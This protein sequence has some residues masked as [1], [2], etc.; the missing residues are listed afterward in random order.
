MPLSPN[1]M[2]PRGLFVLNR[3]V[4][5]DPTWTS[6]MSD[7]LICASKITARPA[8]TTSIIL[9]PAPITLPRPTAQFRI[10]GP[11][12]AWAAGR[13]PHHIDACAAADRPEPIVRRRTAPSTLHRTKVRF[14]REPLGTEARMPANSSRISAN[15]RTADARWASAVVRCVSAIAIGA[16]H[17]LVAA[18]DRQLRRHCIGSGTI[19]AAR[20]EIGRKGYGIAAIAL[21]D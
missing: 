18:E 9:C 17:G 5:A 3:S 6:S 20:K 10:A 2:R 12:A 21:R 7:G 16:Q 1:D 8:G 11:P 14:A 4:A 13:V 15:S 19:I